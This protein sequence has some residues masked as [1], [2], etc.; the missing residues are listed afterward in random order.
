MQFIC[1]ENIKSPQ[2]ATQ[3]VRNEIA[4]HPPR[5][6]PLWLTYLTHLPPSSVTLRMRARARCQVETPPAMTASIPW[7]RST[8]TP[9]YTSLQ[10][11]TPPY[12]SLHILAPP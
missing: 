6:A 4:S 10:L 7:P 9:P 11:L 12:T 3:F 5:S 8:L 1:S 2:M